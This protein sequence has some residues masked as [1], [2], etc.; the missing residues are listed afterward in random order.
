MFSGAVGSVIL[1]TTDDS[2]NSEKA[3]PTKKLVVS[4]LDA[5]LGDEQKIDDPFFR[6][7]TGEAIT[8]VEKMCRQ[9]FTHY[10]MKRF[11]RCGE[12]YLTT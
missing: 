11:A 8:V 5:I 3:H 7:C 1:L 6:S 10:K 9:H 12:A 4:L 2:I